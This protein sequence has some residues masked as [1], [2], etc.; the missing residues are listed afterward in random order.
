MFLNALFKTQNVPALKTTHF[1]FGGRKMPFKGK[2]K[3][4]SFKFLWREKALVKS[5]GCQDFSTGFPPEKGFPVVEQ[6]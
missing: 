1:L 2:K 4:I 5:F 3:G 6:E